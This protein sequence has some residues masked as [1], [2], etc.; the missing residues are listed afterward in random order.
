MRIALYLIVC[1]CL[2][3][4]RKSDNITIIYNDKGLKVDGKRMNMDEMGIHLKTI[5]AG[6]DTPIIRLQIYQ[7]ATMGEVSEIRK[8]IHEAAFK[9]VRAYVK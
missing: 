2:F 4:C 9:D 3:S 7:Q 6:G 1:I 5:T 8:R